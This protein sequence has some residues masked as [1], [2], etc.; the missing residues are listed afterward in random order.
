MTK[1]TIRRELHR[2]L[3]EVMMKLSAEQR[4][5]TIKGVNHDARL[6][7]SPARTRATA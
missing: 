6:P 1:I 2:Q 5:E 3:E 7:N 4:R